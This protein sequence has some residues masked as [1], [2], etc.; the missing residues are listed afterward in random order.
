MSCRFKMPPPRLNVS[1]F[2]ARAHW[3]E[4]NAPQRMPDFSYQLSVCASNEIPGARTTKFPREN[5]QCS[6]N[7]RIKKN[8]KIPLELVWWRLDSSRFRIFTGKGC[9]YSILAWKEPRG[10]ESHKT[11]STLLT[12]KSKLGCKQKCLSLA[13]YIYFSS[14]KNGLFLYKTAISYIWSYFNHFFYHFRISDHI[15]SHPMIQYNLTSLHSWLGWAPTLPR[16]LRSCFTFK[17]YL[18]YLSLSYLI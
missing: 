12:W 2:L 7:S 3:L 16:G 8:Q 1:L 15:V 18:L 11:H 4:G 5:Q 17:Q 10:R 6:P 13:I 9:F 14:Q